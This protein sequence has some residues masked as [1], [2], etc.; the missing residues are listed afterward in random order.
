MA[1][2]GLRILFIAAVVGSSLAGVFTPQSSVVLDVPLIPQELDNWCWAASAAMVKNFLR[3]ELDVQ[4]CAEVNEANGLTGCCLATRDLV[5]CNKV[6]WPQFKPPDF[7]A[8]DGSTTPPPLLEWDDIK[9]EIDA[10]RPFVYARKDIGGGGHIV[11]VQG[12][13][14][15]Q[16]VR[17]LLVS[18]PWPVGV[19]KVHWY[20]H[21]WYKN[22]KKYLRDFHQIQYIG[23]QGE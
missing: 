16:G 4:Q 9:Q 18:D 13:G 7:N 19:G 21:D 14:R 23:G 2:L 22:S 12:Y 15:D 1:N 17:Y 20:T 10:G 11:V 5:E 3:P 8:V 6:G